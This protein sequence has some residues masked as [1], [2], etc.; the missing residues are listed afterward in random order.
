MNKFQIRY[1]KA[2]ELYTALEAKKSELLKPY[3]YLLDSDEGAEKYIELD[4]KA[5]N[6]LG[7]ES[8]REALRTAEDNLIDWLV[9]AVKNNKAYSA[10][11]DETIQM[12]LS[13]R[14]HTIARRRLLDLSLKF[15]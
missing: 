2:N 12:C 5:E 8:V 6:D 15:G 1:T 10:A 14:N 3:D 7:L 13:K 4:I 9:A 11:H